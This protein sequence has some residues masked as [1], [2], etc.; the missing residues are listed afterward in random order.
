[1]PKVQ[2]NIRHPGE[3]FVLRGEN[4]W[5]L[6]RTQWTAF[7]L[8]PDGCTLS[9]DLPRTSQTIAYHTRSDGLSFSTGPLAQAM[10]IT[11]PL[12]AKLLVS[13]ETTDA[14]VFL[15]LR[16]FDGSGKEVSFIGSNDPRT[17]VA[18]GWLRASHRKTD[19]AKS[20]PY[21][22]WHTHDEKQP[23]IPGKAVQMDIE[24]WPTSIVIPAGYSMV[25]NVRG[26]DYRYDDTGVILPFDTQV[27]YG[28]GPF[29]H[30]NPI[31]R[32]AEIFHTTNALHWEPEHPPQVL[33]PI[34]PAQK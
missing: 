10:E 1:M 8:Q 15:A 31:D 25:L 26:K 9:T 20:L 17:P 27:M 2:L 13:S 4:E 19:A 3:K 21:R 34:I 29:T 7:Y 16:V 22:P 24:I 6:A 32:P 33:L 23:L 18:L 12:A 14:D 30:E 11:G 28:V 5:P